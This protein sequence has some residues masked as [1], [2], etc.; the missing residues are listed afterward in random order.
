MNILLKNLFRDIKKSKGQ[1]ISTLIIVILGVT[2]YTSL[3]SVFKNLSN[4]SNKYFEEYRLGDIWVDLY[5]APTSTKEEL[6]KLPEVEMAT[7]RIVKD[8]SIS[9]SE[10]NAT[11]RFITLPD[12]KKNI[13]NDIR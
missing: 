12:V 8:A 11:L 3:N 5:K 2:F 6:E 7:G 10:E 9:I 1:F 4:S 13:V